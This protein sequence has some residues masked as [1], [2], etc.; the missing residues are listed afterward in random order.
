MY[1]NAIEI[2]EAV[3]VVHFGL[4]VSHNEGFSP[5]LDNRVF[6]GAAL[7]VVVHS[8]QTPLPYDRNRIRDRS[9]LR[10]G[11]VALGRSWY[12]GCFSLPRS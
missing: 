1:T 10:G 11:C 12:V 2:D 8:S 7:L 5:L 6:L 4:S 9:T 3:K